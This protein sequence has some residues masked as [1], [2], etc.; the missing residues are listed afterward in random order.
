MLVLLCHRYVH[1]A[2]ALSPHA[3]LLQIRATLQ[4]AFQEKRLVDDAFYAWASLVAAAGEDE[5]ESL[6]DHTFS[7]IVQNWPSFSPQSQTLAHDT[8][9][10]M[11]KSHNSLI[12]D[13]IEMIPSLAGITLLQKFEGEI[14]RF[15]AQLDS[16]I[17]FE[18]F[19]RRCKDESATIVHQALTELIPFLSSNQRMVHESALSQQPSPIIAQVSR[20]V[21]DASVRF[22]ETQPEI[23]DLCAQCL[24]II[25]SIDP[26]RVEALRE[27]REILMLSNFEKANEVIDFVA[28]M[29]E[30]VLVEAF[31]SA[32]T[33]K[34]QTYL[35]YVLQELLKFCGFRQAVVFRPKSSQSTPTYHRWIQIPEAIRS[36]LTPYFNSKYV[37]VHPAMPADGENFPVFKHAMTHGSWLRTL[38]FNLLHKGK[39]DNAQMV[40]PVLSRVIWGHDLAIP[41]FL[42]PFVVLNIVVGGTE[43][44]VENIC[45]EFLTVLAFDIS[46]VPQFEAEN[47]KQCSEVSENAPVR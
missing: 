8:I 10:E 14:S 7:I 46:D 13:R 44:E 29:L 15:K 1:S 33:G 38:V 25:G 34:T 26:N 11:L 9:A 4:S 23:L 45:S 30:T 31:H 3:K 20:S 16:M 27:K 40:F 35:A 41:T 19:S 22:K 32:P 28:S 43:E 42:L 39:G 24:G 36:T 6:V 12:R 47:V 21:L 37:I 18:A 17:H 2:L 5:V